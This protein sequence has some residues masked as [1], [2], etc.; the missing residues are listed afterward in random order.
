[1]EGRWKT[2][3]TCVYNLGYHL[4]WCPKF[5]R[6]VLLGSI[7]TRLKE[8]LLEK[9]SKIHVTIENMETMPDHVHLFVS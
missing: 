2:S 3:S 6:K 4:I 1:M 7:E 9:A 8:L 5:R